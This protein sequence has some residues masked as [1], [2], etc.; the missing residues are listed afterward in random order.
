[1]PRLSFYV[2]EAYKRKMS[3][4]REGRETEPIRV[5]RILRP[6]IE[7]G[8]SKIDLIHRAYKVRR[9]VI[10]KNLSL[11][12]DSGFEDMEV[13][14]LYELEEMA[15]PSLKDKLPPGGTKEERR[16]EFI[17]GRWL[18]W[19]ATA[20]L[21]QSDVVREIESAKKTRRELTE[22]GRKAR[23]S[24]R[25]LPNWVSAFENLVLLKTVSTKIEGLEKIVRTVSNEGTI[26]CVCREGREEDSKQIGGFRISLNLE[27]IPKLCLFQAE[28]TLSPP[29]FRSSFFPQVISQKILNKIYLINYAIRWSIITS[30][31]VQDLAIKRNISL[32]R[33]FSSWAN[34]GPASIMSGLSRL[35]LL[36]IDTNL[37]YLR[38]PDAMLPDLVSFIVEGGT[39]PLGQFAEALTKAFCIVVSPKYVNIVAALT[40]MKTE[41]EVEMTRDYMWANYDSFTDRLVNL[42]L[43]H[44]NPDG[45]VTVGLSR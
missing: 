10:T 31:F 20:D 27:K 24:A 45:E 18:T 43:A 6:T 37:R 44:V 38:L 7:D 28:E 36:K 23:E 40:G 2:E 12:L 34:E 14:S 30:D 26:E 33:D 15:N 16:E 39:M 11:Y 35:G 25:R 13:K 3:V 42:G 21:R 41:T 1:M 4:A 17:R 19:P 29:H 9:G 32:G 5:L 22:F 8:P